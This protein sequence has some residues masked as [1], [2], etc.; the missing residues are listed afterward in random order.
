[1]SN[2]QDLFSKMIGTDK[3][4]IDPSMVIKSIVDDDG[5]GFITRE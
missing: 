1:M 5:K 3:K 4:Y 2:L